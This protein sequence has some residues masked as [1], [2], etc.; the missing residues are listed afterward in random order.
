MHQGYSGELLKQ[1]IKTLGHLF[2]YA[3]LRLAAKGDGYLGIFGVSEKLLFLGTWDPR[4]R[5]SL[6]Q[7]L[8]MGKGN[9]LPLT[10]EDSQLERTTGFPRFKRG[11]AEGGSKEKML[12]GEGKITEA[13]FAL[14]WQTRLLSPPSNKRRDQLPWR[15]FGER[16]LGEKPR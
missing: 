1:A 11:I 10:P 12:T 13:E 2:L 15:L 5:R 8:F 9:P 16:Q 4:A 14:M 6:R 3:H 7:L